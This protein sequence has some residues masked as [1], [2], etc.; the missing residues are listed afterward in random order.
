MFGGAVWSART[1]L[2]RVAPA[3]QLIR[4]LYN[5]HRFPIE[6]FQEVPGAFMHP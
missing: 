4:R 3:A 2:S 1:H 6:R 5:R